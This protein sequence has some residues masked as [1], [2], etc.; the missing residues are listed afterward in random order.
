MG[1]LKA[2]V[3]ASGSDGNC[4][5]LQLGD[6]AIMIDVGLS[7]RRI[8]SLMDTQGIDQESI[9]AILLTHEHTDHV[10][11]A[12]PMAR[13]LDIPIY[14]NRLTYE[15]SKLGQVDYRQIC[16]GSLFNLCGMDIMPLPTSHNAA[17]PN[18][19]LTKAD[20]MNVLVATDTGKLTPQLE[21]A[22]SVSD[23]AIIESNY[24]NQ[25]LTDGP[26]PPNLKRL[27]D[28]DIGHLSNVSCASAIKR[29][30]RKRRQIFLAHLSK[31]NNT[32]DLA[33]ETVANIIGEK[34]YNLDCLE[35]PGDTRTIRVR[36]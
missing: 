4:T 26:Y 17:D 29:T 6:D 31:T 1:L 15:L 34:R 24:D 32:P 13:K 14:C 3:L 12:G 23:L 35:F 30:Q 22:L 19:F 18:A 7:R 25:M 2:H 11:G 9:K 16:T 27:I 10:R 36:V 33:R 8:L 20:D 21:H 5:V 28:S